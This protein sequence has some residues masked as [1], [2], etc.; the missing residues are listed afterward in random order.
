MTNRSHSERFEDAYTRL[1][2]VLHRPDDPDLTQHEREVLHH[3]PASGGVPLGDLAHHLALP[4]STASVLVK[5]LERRG[6]LRRR[7]DPADERRLAI[8][9]TPKGRRRVEADRVLDPDGLGAALAA[10]PPSRRELLLALMER[11]AAAAEDQV[12]PG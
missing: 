3:V 11:V 2:A 7:R 8:V 4:K 5:D 10:L 1:W 6:F 12:R 9:L